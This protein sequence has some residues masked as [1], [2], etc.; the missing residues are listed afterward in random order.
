M[1]GTPRLGGRAGPERRLDVRG[2]RGGT[3]LAPRANVSAQNSTV[4]RALRVLQV[5]LD[6]G[7]DLG[8]LEI[9]A[10]LDLDKS[11]VHRIL[12]T[13]VRRRQGLLAEKTALVVD[14]RTYAQQLDLLRF[15]TREIAEAK[16]E[17]EEESRLEEDH[18]RA[19]NAARLLE[20]GQGGAQLL[21][22][23][24]GALLTHLHRT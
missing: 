11:V 15:Q 8:V 13:L 5:F 2:H 18:R 22:E 20:L 19:S 6:K 14:D 10:T 24:E 4:D 21:S 16:L 7:N 1:V 17:A 9:A 12:A 3:D 23:D